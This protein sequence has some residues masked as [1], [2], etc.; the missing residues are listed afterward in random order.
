MV[1]ID[2]TREGFSVIPRQK[3][4][5]HP[6]SVL[7]R[8]WHFFGESS[9]FLCSYSMTEKFPVWGSGVQP[10]LLKYCPPLL[11]PELKRSSDGINNCHILWSVKPL[12]TYCSKTLSRRALSMISWM[13]VSNTWTESSFIL[14]GRSSQ[15]N[16]DLL[17][18]EKCPSWTFK[19]R[20]YYAL[21]KGDITDS[22]GKKPVTLWKPSSSSLVLRRKDLSKLHG[23]CFPF[24]VGHNRFHS[25]DWK[26][27]R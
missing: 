20:S 26:W 5:H 15:Q 24:D 12:P 13:K 3:T 23:A 7:V 6:N 22:P 11:T 4:R 10:L 25:G 18:R 27:S 21:I 2:G 17:T 14:S 16:N 9:L 19:T 8:Q 1:A